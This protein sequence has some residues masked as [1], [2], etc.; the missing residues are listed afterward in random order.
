MAFYFVRKQRGCSQTRAVPL[1]EAI[2]EWHGGGSGS[3][4]RIRT[5]MTKSLRDRGVKKSSSVSGTKCKA[6]TS[7]VF[8]SDLGWLDQPERG[9]VGESSEKSEVSSGNQIQGQSPYMPTKNASMS[10]SWVTWSRSRTLDSAASTGTRQRKSLL[11]LPLP[12]RYCSVDWYA[13][14]DCNHRWM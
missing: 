13:L 11:R 2:C 3:G 10:S 4:C 6:V 5:D 7:P 8:V 14:R 9:E 1:R 12:L